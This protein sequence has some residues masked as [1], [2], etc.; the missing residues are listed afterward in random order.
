MNVSASS[1]H[2][3]YAFPKD[4]AAQCLNWI[5]VNIKE[6]NSVQIMPYSKYIDLTKNQF[7][8]GVDLGRT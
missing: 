3:H 2:G 4:M 7:E 6:A 1:Q 8:I 5:S